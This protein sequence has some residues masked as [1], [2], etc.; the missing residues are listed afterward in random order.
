MKKLRSTPI[1]SVTTMWDRDTNAS[2]YAHVVG[3]KK[4]GMRGTCGRF[5]VGFGSSHI[6]GQMTLEAE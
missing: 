3:G 1:Y 6:D 4:R 2:L 5:A